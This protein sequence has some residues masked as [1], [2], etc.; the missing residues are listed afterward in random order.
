[1]DLE[2]LLSFTI[3]LK[4][5][6]VFDVSI[7]VSCGSCVHVY[8]RTCTQEHLNVLNVSNRTKKRLKICRYLCMCVAHFLLLLELQLP[9]PL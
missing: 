9:S 5:Q 8:A 1:M 3:L 6:V 2:R 4:L 7:F